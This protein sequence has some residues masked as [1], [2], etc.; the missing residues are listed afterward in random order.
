MK[1][2]WFRKCNKKFITINLIISKHVSHVETTLI[3]LQIP[4]VQ[5]SRGIQYIDSKPL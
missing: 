4:I 1:T 3:C 5:K 2:I